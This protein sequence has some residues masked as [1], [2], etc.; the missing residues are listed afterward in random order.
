[1]RSPSAD[2][3]GGAARSREPRTRRPGPTQSPGGGG[4][5][6]GDKNSLGENYR[7]FRPRDLFPRHLR[8]PSGERGESGD[9]RR[10]G[11]GAAP[12]SPGKV[13][14]SPRTPSEQRG[15]SCRSRVL[16][17][18][19]FHLPIKL[20]RIAQKAD[21]HARDPRSKMLTYCLLPELNISLFSSHLKEVLEQYSK[22]VQTNKTFSFAG[23]RNPVYSIRG[24]ILRSLQI[25]V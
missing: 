13:W 17:F 22:T 2:S 11:P 15:C 14:S 18:A 23:E 1:M 8:E 7:D 4:G 12:G 21:L 3:R 24:H 16:I 20:P 25:W 9:A 5:K 10:G 6:R 19:R